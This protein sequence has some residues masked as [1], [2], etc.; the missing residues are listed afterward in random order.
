MLVVVKKPKQQ[1]WDHLNTGSLVS[2]EKHQRA[3][4]CSC[5]LPWGGPGLAQSKPILCLSWHTLS[6]YSRVS[7]LLSYR[8]YPL[9]AHPF[10]HH[11][12]NSC[13]PPFPSHR[14][15]SPDS[16]PFQSRRPW[17]YHLKYSALLFSPFGRWVI[18][19]WVVTVCTTS[20]EF[21]CTNS[22]AT[23]YRTSVR[24]RLTL[25]GAL[26]LFHGSYRPTEA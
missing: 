8:K 22:N 1:S 15:L 6:Q 4:K 11:I 7:V 21:M 23:L 13:S 17:S 5:L 2:P 26:D 25:T 9:W 3:R 12:M 18:Q 20:P 16:T 24:N 19:V 10:L 14:G